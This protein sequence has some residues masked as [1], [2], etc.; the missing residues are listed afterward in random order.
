MTSPTSDPRSAWSGIRILA[1][2]LDGTLLR[3]DGSLSSRN[4]AALRT[5]SKHGLQVV[6]VTARPLRVLRELGLTDVHGLAICAN[7]ALIA[8]LE[9]DR[10]IS[11]HLLS[12]EDTILIAEQ[13]RALVPGM[14]FAVEASDYFGHEPKY[15]PQ[16]EVPPGSPIG[17][18]G[19]LATP[20]VIKLLGRHPDFTIDRLDE[21]TEAIGSRATATCSTGVGLL[22]IGPAG[23]SKAS[24]L[25]HVVRLIGGSA[26]TVVAVGDMP[27]DL[28][29]LEW[30]SIG[31]AV[32]NAHRRVLES[33]DIVI[34]SNDHDGVAHLIDM[35]LAERPA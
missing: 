31:V 15:V 3:T 19:S 14:T 7:G 26:S 12:A 1:T 11:T 13:V 32:E 25:E 10:L 21:I 6:V 5:A 33:A 35:I 4:E 9:T 16:Y 2:D 22:E 24:S 28:P 23:V 18:I 27:N 17:P 20:G 30:A 34:P 29:M 8:D